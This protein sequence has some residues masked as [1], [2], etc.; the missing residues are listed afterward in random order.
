MRIAIDA[1]MGETRGGIGAYIREFISQLADIDK[2]NQYFVIVNNHG[3]GSFV[4][5]AD[6]FR[7]LMSS[8]TRKHYF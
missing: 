7:I 4:P 3:D 5:S 1:R 6:N 2:K 8:I